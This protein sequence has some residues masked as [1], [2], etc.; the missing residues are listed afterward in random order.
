MDRPNH[1]AMVKPVATSYEATIEAAKKALSEQGFGILSEIEV[2]AA[3]KKRLGVDYPR[4]ILLGACNP[5]YA[6][7]TLLAEPD[8]SVFLP[9]NVVVRE[10]ATGS[11]EVAIIDPAAMAVMI[12]NP[13]VE[14]VAKEVEQR[15]RA[16]LEA[17]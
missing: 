14:A 10:T 16:A 6:H 11:V 2:H 12:P 4:T 13:E 8:I 9:C 15:L 17:L 5:T 1:Y 3:L 7:R